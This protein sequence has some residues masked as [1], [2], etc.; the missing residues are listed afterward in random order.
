MVPRKPDSIVVFPRGARGLTVNIYQGEQEHVRFLHF[1]IEV[2][3][4]FL[5]HQRWER[6]EPD[7]VHQEEI[8]DS[9]ALMCGTSY[10]VYVSAC[11]TPDADAHS[12]SEELKADRRTNGCRPPRP[13]RPPPPPPRP[14][15]PPLPPPPSPSPPPPPPVY[16]P[17]WTGPT[18]PSL[19]TVALRTLEAWPVAA[20]AG[21]GLGTLVVCAALALAFQ[22]RRTKAAP[23]RAVT[24]P[25]P[26]SACDM[27]APAPPKSARVVGQVHIFRKKTDDQAPLMEDQLTSA[28]A[29]ELTSQT[30]QE[31]LRAAQAQPAAHS[32]RASKKGRKKGRRSVPAVDMADGD[33]EASSLRRSGE[34]GSAHRL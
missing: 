1:R 23:V 5:V 7:G 27:E 29:L 8:L 13:P 10:T 17:G 6:F 26:D 25:L 15:P 28:A 4:H 18:P 20:F 30:S 12:C 33:E 11:S 9:R 24:A 16:P 31:L 32:S 2:G 19:V 3:S 34:F 21:V 22:S 14:P